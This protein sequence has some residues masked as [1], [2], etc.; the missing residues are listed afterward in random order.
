MLLAALVVPALALSAPPQVRSPE[1][2]LSL[3]VPLTRRGPDLAAREWDGNADLNVLFS[4]MNCTRVKYNYTSPADC[5]TIATTNS[6]S[7]RS[8]E[9]R[10]SQANISLIDLVRSTFCL[11]YF[12]AQLNRYAEHRHHILCF[13]QRWYPV[14]Y[15][16]PRRLSMSRLIKTL[17]GHKRSMS[18]LTQDPPISGL[19][20]R[21]A[22]T[23]YRT[24]L[25]WIQVVLL[26]SRRLPI[27]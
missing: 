26:Q 8:L 3:H 24:L 7:R 11:A 5:S 17:P 1:T 22:T 9:S 18:S 10:Q 16:F 6:T 4:L 23:V 21:S 12:L 20:R 15:I 27:A 14:R 25:D 19:R 13:H 2:G